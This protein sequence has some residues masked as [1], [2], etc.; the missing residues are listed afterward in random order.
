MK[1]EKSLTIN[2]GGYQSIRIGAT[3]C[4][5]FDEANEALLQEIN[6]IERKMGITINEIRKAVEL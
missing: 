3:D 4:N 2:T 5:S 1:I 6:S